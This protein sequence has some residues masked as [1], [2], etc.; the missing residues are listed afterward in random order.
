MKITYERESRRV[1]VS[2]RGRLTVLPDLYSTREEA[3]SAGESYCRR[4]GWIA[5]R[6]SNAVRRPW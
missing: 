6:A 1:I 3:V 5:N 4:Q 2:F